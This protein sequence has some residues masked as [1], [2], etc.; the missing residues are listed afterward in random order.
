MEKSV[1]VGLYKIYCF[2]NN[3]VVNKTINKGSAMQR[4][5]GT[6]I[7]ISAWICTSLFFMYFGSGQ[8]N[9]KA[10]HLVGAEFRLHLFI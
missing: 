5:F 4:H 9:T 3:P 1:L 7:D 10:C 8:K 2:I 6:R